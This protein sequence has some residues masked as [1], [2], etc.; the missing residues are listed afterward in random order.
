MDFVF[1]QLS[2]DHVYRLLAPALVSKLEAA[3]CL[4]LR[5]TIARPAHSVCT[6][7]AAVLRSAH[8]TIFVSA[9]KPTPALLLLP[10]LGWLNLPASR[11][12]MVINGMLDIT[13]DGCVEVEYA[14][15][16]A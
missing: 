4:V 3:T 8:R 7:P 1:K 16:S 13:M 15:E 11:F 12:Q 10:L 2:T 14:W 6:I 9:T 5:I